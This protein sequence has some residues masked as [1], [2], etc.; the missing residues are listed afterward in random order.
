MSTVAAMIGSAI[1][2]G[3]EALAGSTGL[4]CR[5]DAQ[6]WTS[7]RM[8]QLSAGE[9]WF[10][11]IGSERIEF[12]HDGSGLMR[13]RSAQSGADSWASVEPRWEADQSLCWGTVCARGDLRLD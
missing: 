6:V 8:H 2:T 13:M 11:E 12:R 4:Q 9:H 1:W 7:C 5:R 3:S 10:L